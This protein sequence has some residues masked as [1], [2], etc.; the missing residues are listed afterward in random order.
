M[1]TT[2]KSAKKRESQRDGSLRSQM[3]LVINDDAKSIWTIIP[4]HH[5]SKQKDIK[6]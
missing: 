1:H 4:H 3:M 6:I 5:G 2:I